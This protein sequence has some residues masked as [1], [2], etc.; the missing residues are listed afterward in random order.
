MSLSIRATKNKSKKVGRPRTTGSGEQVVV[1][2][3]E[4][5]LGAI[6]E[7]IERQSPARPSRPE[8]IRRLVEQALAAAPKHSRTKGKSA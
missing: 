7:W 1:R 2:M 3:H 8:A 4:P 5:M 6:D